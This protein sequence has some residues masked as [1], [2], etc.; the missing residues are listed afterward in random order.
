V[1]RAWGNVEE[2]LFPHSATSTS[3]QAIRAMRS[4]E[5]LEELRVKKPQ[6]FKPLPPVECRFRV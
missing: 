2:K 1:N 6:F 4:R 5:A 3:S